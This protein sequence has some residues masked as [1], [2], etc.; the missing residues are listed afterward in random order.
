M[1]VTT[2]AA[3]LVL[4]LLT[5]CFAL[6]QKEALTIDGFEG[7]I[8]GGPQG[9]VDFGAG[10]GSKVAVSAASQPAYS[11]KQSLKIDYDA[12]QAGYIWV[13]RGLDLDAKNSGWQVK[14]ESIDWKKYNAFGFYVYG[15][16][17]KAKVAF[18]IK[19]SG[20]EIFRYIFEDNFKGWK[21]IV[22]PFSDFIARSDWQ[23]AGA[24]KNGA[25]DFPIKSYQFEPMPPAK[26][27]LYFAQIEVIKK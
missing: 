20:N 11:G 17:S 1:R 23:P 12:V 21:Q 4:A 24:D 27:A 9:T 16:G 7:A 8:S 19:D 5:A 18:D 15:S 26:G 13:A 2:F 25:I 22:C 3:V 6:D 14:P 10:N